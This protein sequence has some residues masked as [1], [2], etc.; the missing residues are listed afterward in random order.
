MTWTKL[1][2][3]RDVQR[4]RTSKKELDDVRALIARDLA[5]A[6]VTALSADRRFATAYNAALLTAHML[7]ACA[8]YRVTAK[9][10]HHKVAFDAITLTLGASASK[11]ADYFER[12]R[13]KRNVIDYTRS[14]VATETEAQEILEKATEFRGF[15]EAW[16]D[17]KFPAL[18][19][20]E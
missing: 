10:G 14:H 6:G 8:G 19:R 15:V 11:Y 12:C 7:I 4:H 9:T 3:S 5:D 13:R 1:L 17:S 2:A 16:I 20:R 18:K